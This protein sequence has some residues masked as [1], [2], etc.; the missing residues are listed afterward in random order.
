M[1]GRVQCCKRCGLRYGASLGH[2]FPFA[3][4][5]QV[6]V[7]WDVSEELLHPKLPIDLNLILRQ[8]QTSTGGCSSSTHHLPPPRL[9]HQQLSMT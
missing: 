7:H 6:G 5:K 2:S 9:R 4:C 8:S 1:L 3:M